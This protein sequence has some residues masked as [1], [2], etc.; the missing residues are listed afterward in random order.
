MKDEE[1]EKN[2][3]S[4]IGELLEGLTAPSTSES[5]TSESSEANASKSV[6]I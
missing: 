4:E 2:Q 1:L 5:A 3:Q 6:A